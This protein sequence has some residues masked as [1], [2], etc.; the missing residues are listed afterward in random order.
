MTEESTLDREAISDK[1]SLEEDQTYYVAIGASAGGL[2]AIKLLFQTMPPETGAAFII[3]QHL[4]PDFKSVMG[5]LLRRD[6]T[7]SIYNAED[8]MKV[9]ANCIYLIPPKK[10]M[11][12]A[13]GKLILVDQMP[14]R[15]VNFPIDIFFRSLAED[16]QHHSVGI[17]LSGTGSDGSRGIQAI[18]EVGGLVLVQEPKDAK[19]DGMPYSAVNSG[20]SD[21]V[22]GVKEIPDKLVKYI[23]HPLIRTK[24]EH[25]A[26]SLKQ[27]QQALEEI[28]KVLYK[29]T[30]IDFTA[31]KRGTLV[32]R[33]ERRVGVHQFNGLT[34]YFNLLIQDPEELRTLSKDMLIGVT[35]F[36]RDTECFDTIEK[37]AAPEIISGLSEHEV[38]K[39]WVAGCSTGEEAYSLAIVFSEVME[40]LNKRRKIKIFATDVDPN[41]ISEASMGRFDLNIASDISD[42]RLNKY[43]QKENDQYVVTPNLRQMIVFATHNLMKDPPFS[44][45]HLSVCRNVLIYFQPTLQK[46]VLSMLHFSL[47]KG[48]FLFLGPSESLSEVANYFDP[49]NERNRVYKKLVSTNLM[50]ERV[51]HGDL[52]KTASPPPMDTLISHYQRSHKS[53]NSGVVLETLSMYYNIPPCILLDEKQDVLYLFGD[54]SEVTQKPKQGN[55]SS[56]INDVLSP[57]LTV[58]ISTAINRVKSSSGSVL[59]KELAVTAEKEKCLY[60]VRVCYLKNTSVLKDSYIIFFEKQLDQQEAKLSKETG[61][62]EHNTA[63]AADTE[64]IGY[65]PKKEY[66]QRIHDL[67]IEVK[68]GREHLQITVEELETTNEEL[69]SSNEELLSANEELQS[70]NEELQSVNE[71]L[72][73]VNAEYHDKIGDLTKANADIDNLMKTTEL[74]IIFLDSSLLIRRFTEAATTIFHLLPTDIE[75]PFHH[76]SNTLNYRDIMSDISECAKEKRAIEKELSTHNKER[77]ILKILPYLDDADQQTGVVLVTNDITEV[78]GLET[79]MAQSYRHF[80]D[81][82]RSLSMDAKSAAIPV[83]IVDDKK[84]DRQWLSGLFDKVKHSAYEFYEAE[85]V[86]TALD[87]LKETKIKVCLIDYK[88]SS[89]TNALDMIEDLT[90]HHNSAELPVFILLSSLLTSD[91]YQRAN[92]LPIYDAIAKEDLTGLFLDRCI[93]HA[94]QKREVEVFFDNALI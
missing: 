9:A 60:N 86:E 54:V 89:H 56:S 66:Q 88:L 27:D 55:F 61:V 32:R 39:I 28:L 43:F 67:E 17:I 13:E 14:T 11:M 47:V 92:T 64:V 26:N 74:G 12:I 84:S 1:G 69:Q 16:Q 48:G 35:R 90:K 41:A 77:I 37:I 72:Y 82:M 34:D 76:I 71:E 6:T 30:S 87:T 52:E 24:S 85:S 7:M 46:K 15:G 53:Q 36:F 10:N 19:F 49:I 50:P 83:L 65:N 70:T 21:L 80:K 57:D 81:T 22:L 58:A 91:I 20:F 33:I 40:K 75:R 4:S 78:R 59:Y 3:I 8:G 29:N 63:E 18:K 2:E 31:Y 25:S 94:L 79:R 23:T 44:N 68:E 38:V 73:T 45:T 51:V 93:T 62:R 42:E 5:D